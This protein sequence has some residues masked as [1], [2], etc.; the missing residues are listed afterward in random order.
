[1]VHNVEYVMTIVSAD[2]TRLSFMLQSMALSTH[3]Q[4]G[5]GQ[6]VEDLDR[7]ACNLHQSQVQS[8]QVYC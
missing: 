3:L 4:S 6:C 2:S 5:E 7:D 8:M 1:M